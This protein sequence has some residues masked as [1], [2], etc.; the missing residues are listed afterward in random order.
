[1]TVAQVGRSPATVVDSSFRHPHAVWQQARRHFDSGELA[2]LV[3]TITVVN[4][5]NRVAIST[6]MPP[7]G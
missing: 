5:W 1:V 6:R 4:G 2:R 7:A 3:W